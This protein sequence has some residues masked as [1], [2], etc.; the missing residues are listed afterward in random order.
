MSEYQIKREAIREY[1][2]AIRLRKTYSEAVELC[3]GMLRELVGYYEG[4][5]LPIPERVQ[6]LM[7]A[8]VREVE[9]DLP[10]K[11]EQPKETIENDYKAEQGSRLPP[12]ASPVVQ[13]P[14]KS[15]K[16]ATQP[17]SEKVGDF[18]PTLSTSKEGVPKVLAPH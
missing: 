9:I 12:C 8:L 1:E 4:N 2:E 13:R 15:P 5:G 10:T 11:L 6:R 7:L 14:K 16:D 3:S 17:M 18:V